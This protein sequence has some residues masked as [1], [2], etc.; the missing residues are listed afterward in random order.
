MFTKIS[1]LYIFDFDHRNTCIQEVL[2]LECK[3]IY[4]LKGIS[5]SY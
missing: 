2:T 5:N 1:G 4:K 3:P